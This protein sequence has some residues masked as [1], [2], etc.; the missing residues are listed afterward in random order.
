MLFLNSKGMNHQYNQKHIQKSSHI[1]TDFHDEKIWKNN[2][3]FNNEKFLHFILYQ[4][5]FEVAYLLGWLDGVLW[6]KVHKGHTAPEKLN[7]KL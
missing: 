2:Y 1:L 7:Q 5:A 4:D 6:H 3:F